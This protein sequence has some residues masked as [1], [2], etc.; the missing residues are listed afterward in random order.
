MRTGPP[1]GPN[2]AGEEK[3]MDATKVV[4]RDNLTE[5]TVELVGDL[6]KGDVD[7]LNEVGERIAQETGWDITV[8]AFGDGS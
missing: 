4:I 6:P 2:P 8:V 5:R 1:G 7:F 3:R